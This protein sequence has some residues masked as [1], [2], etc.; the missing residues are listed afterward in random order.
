[1][2]G[3]AMTLTPDCCWRPLGP[4]EPQGQS[5]DMPEWLKTLFEPKPEP[6]EYVGKHRRDAL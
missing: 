2:C 3:S 4:P 5:E 6:V 1:M